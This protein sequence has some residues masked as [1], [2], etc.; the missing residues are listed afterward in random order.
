MN[1]EKEKINSRK[2]MDG[3]VQVRKKKWRDG[4]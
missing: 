1:N 4:I 2:N 3:L